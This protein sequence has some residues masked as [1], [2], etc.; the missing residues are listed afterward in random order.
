MINPKV[1]VCIPAYNYGRYLKTC[2]TSVLAQAYEDYE[3]ILVDNAST[4]ETAEVAHSFNDPRVRYF[5][6]ANTV[7]AVENHNKAFSL[8]QGEYIALLA[9]DDEFLPDRLFRCVELL[10]RYPEVGLVYSALIIVDAEGNAVE[11][12][13]PYLQDHIMP[14][15][16]EFASLVQENHIA[17]PT[18]MFRNRLCR[19]VG[20]FRPL[21]YSPDWDM[22]L[23]FAVRSDLAY[24]ATPLARYRVHSASETADYVRSGQVELDLAWT[25]RSA[26][27]E[28]PDDFH[29]LMPLRQQVLPRYCLPAAWRSFEIDDLNTAQ[30]YLRVA[31]EADPELLT[32]TSPVVASIVHFSVSQRLADTDPLHFSEE[33]C[34]W[35]AAERPEFRPLKRRVA[36][37]VHT[38]LAFEAHQAGR[39]DQ[40]RNHA[41]RAVSGDPTWLHNRGFLSISLE[42][43]V[44]RALMEHVRRLV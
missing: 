38:A 33:L 37:G 17:C 13:C 15:K 20:G 4:D 29:D 42:S 28:L 9:A 7:S 11:T 31:L 5:R 43:L 21:R 39:P 30:S 2:V 22:W 12:V 16:Q 41:I 27:L 35:L 24:I 6:N 8:A 10:N 18:V 1:S 25:V 32:D 34:G 26:F 19:E 36:S 23:R 40:V 14:G 3:I 44:G